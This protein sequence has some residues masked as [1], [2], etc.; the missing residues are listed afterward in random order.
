MNWKEFL[1][2]KLAELGLPKLAPVLRDI[3]RNILFGGVHLRPRLKSLWGEQE[4]RVYTAAELINLWRDTYGSNWG[5]DAW[6]RQCTIRQGLKVELQGVTLHEY[7]SIKPGFR[8]AARR[9]GHKEQAKEYFPQ[10][11]GNVTEEQKAVDWGKVHEDIGILDVR[12]GSLGDGTKRR[13]LLGATAGDAEG[14]PSSFPVVVGEEVYQQLDERLRSYGAVRVERISGKIGLGD[15]R[16]EIPFRREFQRDPV[17]L[18]A[19][20]QRVIVMD[21]PHQVLG[22]AWTMAK[23]AGELRTLAFTF[24]LGTENWDNQ[25]ESQCEEVEKLCRENGGVP[26]VDFDAR[27]KRFPSAVFHPK[28]VDG[29]YEKVVQKL[30]EGELALISDPEEEKPRIPIV[31]IQTSSLSPV[32][33]YRKEGDRARKSEGFSYDKD[34]AKIYLSYAPE[35]EKEVEDLHQRLSEAG[36][37]P[38]MDKID[39]FP[40]EEFESSRERAV[41]SSN[42]FLICLS[43]SSANRRG[44]FQKDIRDALNLWQEKL[45][46]DIYLIPAKLEDSEVPESLRGFQWVNL[47]EAD[48]WTRLLQAIQEGMKRLGTETDEST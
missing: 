25:L 35:D 19:D 1:D 4:T 9:T 17:F 18:N 3:S 7:L 12:Y 41:R 37:S 30:A 29:W 5:W 34:M 43:A 21:Q 47:F 28:A 45:K 14:S 46:R 42:F 13:Y 10:S 20:T 15:E 26:L 27:R 39:I 40:G 31:S 2:Q 22:D 16:L 6:K 23:I 44:L 32:L 36:H 33:K 38:W 48:G 8:Y 11:Y 24:A